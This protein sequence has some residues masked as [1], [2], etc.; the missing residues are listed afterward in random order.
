MRSWFIHVSLLYSDVT[1][2]CLTYPNQIS[3]L[4]GKQRKMLV[5]EIEEKNMQIERQN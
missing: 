4:V 3:I 1:Y 2:A 5:K